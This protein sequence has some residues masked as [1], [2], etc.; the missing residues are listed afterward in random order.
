M[1]NKKNRIRNR[2][3]EQVTR[4]YN[5]HY[6]GLGQ[7]KSQAPDKIRSVMTYS[8]HVEVTALI[9]HKLGIKRVKNITVDI[10]N[11]YIDSQRNKIAARSLENQRTLLQRVIDIYEPGQKVDINGDLTPRE[12]VNRAY[13]YEQVTTLM[14][15]QK[16]RMRLS[17]AIAFSAGLRAQELLTLRRFDEAKP[18]EERS[19]LDE[20]F[21]GL[22]GVKYIVKGKGGLCREV[23][24]P[25]KLA[26]LLETKRL[27]KPLVVEDRKVKIQTY[28]D[29]AGGKKFSD[30]FSQ[31]STSLFGWSHGAHGLRYSYA[32]ARMNGTITQESYDARKEIVS[33]E[34]G[35]FRKEITTH[36]LTSSN[37]TSH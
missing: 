13:T 15:H 11:R 3:E 10:A 33:Q 2:I 34:L 37:H 4:F 27:P 1:G 26:Q 5:H 8:R 21:K 31:L 12:W 23:L 19:W 22:D 29:I 9:M 17:T 36:Y 6:Y 32:Q 25:N 20:R 16:E 18:S 7:T 24:L 30:A 14:S 35:H 28:Y